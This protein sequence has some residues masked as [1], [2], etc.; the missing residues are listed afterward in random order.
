V[1]DIQTNSAT[2]LAGKTALITAGA[3]GMGRAGAELLAKHGAHVIAV[4]KNGPGMDAVVAG[5][6]SQGG[7]AEA[8]TATYAT[9]RHSMASSLRSKNVMI[10]STCCTTTLASPDRSVLS[11]MRRA[12]AN[13]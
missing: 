5:I 13:A 10:L 4:D 9:R 2:K 8:H 12:G 3:S 7:S 6:L 11:L 1:S